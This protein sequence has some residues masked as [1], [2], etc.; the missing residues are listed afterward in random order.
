MGKLAI[1]V[2]VRVGMISNSL[3]WSK[4]KMTKT[5]WW[6]SGLTALHIRKLFGLFHPFSIFLEMTDVRIIVSS[7]SRQIVSVKNR[8]ADRA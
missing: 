7:Q 6:P 8:K 4:V 1:R 3:A 5:K 2:R